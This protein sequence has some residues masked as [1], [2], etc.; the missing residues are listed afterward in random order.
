MNL[1][2]H[3]RD[4]YKL[5]CKS[6]V[7]LTGAEFAVVLMNACNHVCRYF[8]SVIHRNILIND[9]P[10]SGRPRITNPV[11]DRY[12]R[13]FQPRNINVT[14]SQTPSS[15]HGLRRISAQ[16][17]RNRL[18][19][20]GKRSRRPYFVAVLKRQH[21]RAMVRWHSTVRIWDLVKSLVQWLIQVH[22]CTTRWQCSSL[23]TP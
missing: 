15:I 9:S 22:A 14:A 23:K 20:D 1:L 19:E 10:R 5:S 3:C 13:V 16:T 4:V 12:I 11:D 7:V 21:R 6:M 18:R 2:S 8:T 17:V